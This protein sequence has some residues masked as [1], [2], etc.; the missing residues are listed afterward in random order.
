PMGAALN[1]DGRYLAVSNDGTGTQSL[2]LVDTATRVV[3]QRIP[4]KSPQAL[5]V[6]V[7]WMPDGRGLFASAG[8]NDK[9]RTYEFRGG[10]PPGGAARGGRPHPPPPPPHAGPP[11]VPARP[12]G[13]ARRTHAPR[14]AKPS[15]DRRGDRSGHGPAQ[16][17]SGHGFAAVRCRCERERRESLRQ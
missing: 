13:H 7:A 4:Y 12:D 6:G 17:G 3:V 10:P 14:C 15:A 2:V 5:H 16:S 1:P 9:I 8:G 11:A